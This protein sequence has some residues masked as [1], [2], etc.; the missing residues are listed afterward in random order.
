[1]SSLFRSIGPVVV[2]A[3][4]C[5]LPGTAAAEFLVPSWRGS[6]GAT[7]Y[8]WANPYG[9]ETS[10]GGDPELFSYAPGNSA[11]PSPAPSGTASL[12][13]PLVPIGSGNF[14]NGSFGFGTFTPDTFTLSV[15]SFLQSGSAG[16]V[17]LQVRGSLGEFGSFISS[18]R[19]MV[20]S[21]SV[22]ASLIQQVTTGT[23]G[24]GGQSSTVVEALY[25]WDSIVT[26]G[27]LLEIEFE[28]ANHVSLMSLSVDASATIAA[29]PE[30][31]SASLA[32]AALV[33]M[34]GAIR[35]FV[36]RRR[37]FTTPNPVVGTPAG[38]RSSSC[39]SSSPSSVCSSGSCSRRCSRR[40]KAP[41]GAGA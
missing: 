28:N 9:A 3:L 14:Y 2:A 41:V 13:T 23:A 26:D 16:T 19:L 15:P 10:L 6:A 7:W 22:A 33:G 37:S 38:S 12:V 8:Q 18:P 34:G 1:M 5:I 31:T 29:V 35:R 4:L 32:A 20:G 30:P 27:G 25:A 11:V 40:E 39:S 17:M 36:R 24:G 21:G